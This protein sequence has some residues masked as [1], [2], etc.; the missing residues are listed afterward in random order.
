V[1]LRDLRTGDVGLNLTHAVA[2]CDPKSVNVSGKKYRRETI[3]RLFRSVI[4]SMKQISG[5]GDGCRYRTR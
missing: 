2:L 4:E 3:W 1:K 5:A